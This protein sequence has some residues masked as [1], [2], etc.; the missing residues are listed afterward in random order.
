MAALSDDVKLYIVQQLACYRSPSQVVEDV[1]ETFGL[2]LDRRQVQKYNPDQCEKAACWRDR[3]DATRAAFLKDQAGIGIAQTSYRLRELQEM[4]LG[5]R[6][7]G[8]TPLAA[9]L[10]EQ[11]AKECGGAYTNTRNLSAKVGMTIDDILI[12]LS[13]EDEEAAKEARHG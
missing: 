10:L 13:I 9:E 7:K 8:N 2:K 5:A 12:A 4:Y 3:F 11:A 6:S 1:K